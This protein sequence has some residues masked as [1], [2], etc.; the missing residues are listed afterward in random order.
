MVEAERQACQQRARKQYSHLRLH[1]P[2]KAARQF[3]RHAASR[4]AH[5]KKIYVERSTDLY[6]YFT[7]ICD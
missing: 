2:L 5:Y 7:M 4:G 1:D 3:T 6:K